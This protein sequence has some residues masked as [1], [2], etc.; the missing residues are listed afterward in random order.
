M[1]DR[2]QFIH[3]VSVSLLGAPCVAAAQP[4][5]KIYRLGLLRPAVP[6]EPSRV[7]P[8]L[9]ELGYVEGQNLVVELR[10]ADGQLDRL[11]A[12]AREL[13]ALRVDVILSVSAAATRAAMA[14]TATIP[15]VFTGNFDPVA[16]GVV[17]SLARPGGNVTGVLIGVGGDTLVGKRL[18]LLKE[19]V[20]RISRI[21]LLSNDEPT[22]RVQELEAQKAATSLGIDL[23]IGQVRGG[24]FERAFAAIA[25]ERPGA[26]LVG[27]SSILDLNQQRIF[28]FA[29]KYRL[30]AIYEW[31]R[32]AAAG[33]LMAYSSD[34]AETDRRAAVKIDRILKGAKPADLPVEQPTKF[35]F[36]INLK[37]A[38]A[39]GLVIP[40]SL[41]LRADEVI[42]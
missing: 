15:I 37:T 20:P 4:A 2:R 28:A 32:N 16:A 22:V 8:I 19:A 11:P 7:L 13:V 25:A 6:A 17:A 29:A 10:H 36:V 33:G 39:L 38:K 42:Q 40:Q 31:P 12:L 18:E 27:S 3:I 9:R 34:Q 35:R 24:D 5:G 14:A 21:A 30:P 41:L 23:V 26:L 1:I